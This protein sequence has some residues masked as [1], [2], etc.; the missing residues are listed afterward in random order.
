MSTQKVT[1]VIDKETLRKV[2]LN[3]YNVYSQSTMATRIVEWA[4]SRS[5]VV[6]MALP[7][8]SFYIAS[9]EDLGM[10]IVADKDVGESARK[11]LDILKPEV[12]YTS[13][14]C[15]SGRVKLYIPAGV[16]VFVYKSYRVD[17]SPIVTR[18]DLDQPLQNEVEAYLPVN[19][20]G[21]C[22]VDGTAAIVSW[23]VE[24]AKTEPPSIGERIILL[25]VEDLVGLQVR[26]GV[27]SKQ[28][29]DSPDDY[30][31]EIVR[32]W[33]P[34]QKYFVNSVLWAPPGPAG[35]PAAAFSVASDI[36]NHWV[37]VNAESVGMGILSRLPIKVS[38]EDGKTLYGYNH[39]IGW[40]VEDFDLPELLE[41]IDDPDQEDVNILSLGLTL[42]LIP[43]LVRNGHPFRWT[44]AR[45]VFDDRDSLV[46]GSVEEIHIGRGDTLD[47]Q[48]KSLFGED[49][50]E[51]EEE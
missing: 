31:L 19:T 13:H 23:W 25:S 1:D 27:G 32:S 28:I 9:A 38:R 18:M 8:D 33:E 12:V 44:Y 34:P 10:E 45:G 40:F 4:M 11:I 5:D 24:D 36:V 49:D 41:K 16:R 50:E 30:G 47:E 22:R 46:V 15:L 42:K 26:K 43:G 14:S 2:I 35:H 21:S 37:A 29:Y 51:D 20:H 17:T 7:D 39:L 3:S 6:V 48:L